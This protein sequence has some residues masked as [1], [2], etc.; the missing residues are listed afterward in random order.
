MKKE[1]LTAAVVGCGSLGQHY[2]E[3]YTALPDVDLI[4]IAEYNPERRKVVGERFGVSALFQ[5][6]EE[7]VK[8][9]VP[10]VVACALPGKWIFESVMAAIDA[11][12]RGVSSDKPL[13]A[14]LSE[15]DEMVKASQ[16]KG[17]VFAGGNLQRAMY[18]VQEAARW[19]QNGEF[20]NLVG[21]SMH[22][23]GGQISGGG[24]QHVSVLRLFTGAEVEEVIAWGKP[25]EALESD[26]DE[27]LIINGTFKMT[28]GLICNVFGESTPLRGVDVWSEESLVRWDWGAPEVYQGFDETAARI[29]LDRPYSPYDWGQ[30]YYLGASI[31]SFLDA[32]KNG[33]GELSIS[34]HDLR[35]ALEVAIAAKLSAQRG[36]VPV[37]LPLEDRS[38]ILYPTPARW[39]GRDP[40]GNTQP[41]EDAAKSWKGY[42]PELA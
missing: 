33:G 25:Q 6:A 14:K 28:S 37:K 41:P 13:G 17:I 35:Q 40:L 23:W 19:L 16:S 38:A 30:Y 26:G 34:G 18:E 1:K 12:V 22:G 5:D 20:G 36:S 9:V 31:R 21:A 2:A 8:S 39:L 32:V 3:V 4:A 10:D 42:K 11:G 15:A 24:C 7:M 29:K 27:G